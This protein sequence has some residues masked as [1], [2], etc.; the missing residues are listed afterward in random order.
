MEEMKD[1]YTFK[2][3]YTEA[4][5]K[6]LIAWFAPRMDKLPA[7]LQLNR[8]SRTDDLPH[9]V[10]RMVGVITEKGH[11]STFSGYISHLFLIRERLKEQGME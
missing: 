4:E 8:S 2:S 7:A 11:S 6:E 9:T 3:E 10:R 1:I 5:V